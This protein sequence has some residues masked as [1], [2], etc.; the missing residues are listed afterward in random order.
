MTPALMTLAPDAKE[1]WVKFHD[2]IE[3]Q[4]ASGGDLHEVRDVA[5]KVADN[6]VRLA[7][8]F[9]IFENGMGPIGLLAFEAASRVAAWHLSE[10]RR[11]F[12]ELA[13]PVEQA[14]AVRLDT[15]LI[16]YCRNTKTNIV[17]KN[18]VRQRGPGPLRHGARLDAAINELAELDR[19]RLTKDGRRQ[20]IAVNPG[21]LLL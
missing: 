21:L 19:L 18:H 4:L 7:A 17:G 13:L 3:G 20:T 16:E 1:A 9:E 15:W 6:A 11:F 10:A 12:G 14:D 8:L 5:S 2:G